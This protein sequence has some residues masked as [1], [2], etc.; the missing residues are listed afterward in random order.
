MILQIRL[1]YWQDHPD[2]IPYPDTQDDAFRQV[3][4]FALGWAL[5]EVVWSIAQGYEQLALYRDVLDGERDKTKWET[6]SDD[7]AEVESISHRFVHSAFKSVTPPEHSPYGQSRS[8]S[9]LDPRANGHQVN[10][11]SEMTQLI[12]IQSRTELESVYGVPP[13]NIPVFIFILQRLDA[14]LLTI[15]LT[16]IVSSTY[17]SELIAHPLTQLPSHHPSSPEPDFPPRPDVVA[18]ALGTVPMYIILVLV[19]ASLAM[20]WT[21]ALP[22]IGIHTASYTALLIALGVFFVGLASWGALS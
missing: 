5:V 10:L 8:L 20:M 22:K 21:E 11:D 18:A 14:M 16:L 9:I 4:W 13:P 19:H 12:N 17:L 2:W 15:G 3:F 6:G 1:S 7:D